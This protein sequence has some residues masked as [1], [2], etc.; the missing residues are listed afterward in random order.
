MLFCFL[1]PH[2]QTHSATISAFFPLHMC[3]CLILSCQDEQTHKKTKF[4]FVNRNKVPNRA[5]NSQTEIKNQQKPEDII[6]KGIKLHRSNFFS[7]GLS[8]SFS[9]TALPCSSIYA[10]TNIFFTLQIGVKTFNCS[11][12]LLFGCLS[13]WCL[14]PLCI[15]TQFDDYILTFIS[16]LFLYSEF[17]FTELKRK[18]TKKNHF[19]SRIRLFLVCFFQ[20]S[21]KASKNYDVGV[22]LEIYM[23]TNNNQIS[24]IQGSMLRIRFGFTWFFFFLDLCVFFNMCLLASSGEKRNKI[25]K[26]KKKMNANSWMHKM[27][28]CSGSGISEVTDDD[29]EKCVTFLLTKCVRPT[30][31]HPPRL[32]YTPW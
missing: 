20:V 21:Y 6:C 4:R 12:L 28:A 2:I 16:N 25:Q 8:S 10:H 24:D 3:C 15:F 27:C 1:F 22:S 18:E 32:L 30:F 19:V 26:K 17:L 13:S 7:V 29:F 9:S 31:V 5:A 14:Y 11:A 23:Q